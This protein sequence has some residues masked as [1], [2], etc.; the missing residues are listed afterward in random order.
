MTA[1]KDH[2]KPPKSTQ[3]SQAE[4]KADKRAAALRDNLKKRKALAQEKKSNDDK[5]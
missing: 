4:I 1:E 2:I 5:P 3:R